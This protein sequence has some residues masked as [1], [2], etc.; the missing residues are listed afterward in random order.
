MVPP[1]SSNP[2]HSLFAQLTDHQQLAKD[3][4]NQME[5]LSSPDTLLCFSGDTRIFYSSRLFSSKRNF[6]IPMVVMPDAS[7]LSLMLSCTTMIFRNESPMRSNGRT[8]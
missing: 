7:R 6:R 3:M 1:A 4:Q 2:N 8:S 5:N